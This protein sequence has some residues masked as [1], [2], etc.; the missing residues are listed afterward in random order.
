MTVTG[1]IW[2][3]TTRN[4][5]FPCDQ[6]GDKELCL[7]LTAMTDLTTTTKKWFY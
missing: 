4:V 7:L 6:H 1:V 3:F 5:V 2:L